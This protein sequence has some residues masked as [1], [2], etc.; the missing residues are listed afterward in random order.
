MLAYAELIL[1][2][3]LDPTG[4]LTLLGAMGFQNSA[5]LFLAKH[6]R[7]NEVEADATGLTIAALACYDVRRGTHFMR[8]LSEA[9]GSRPTS[10]W[11]T[12]PATEDRYADLRSSSLGVHE[13]VYGSHCTAVGKALQRLVTVP[14]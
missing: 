3:F 6:S 2:A 7:E 13:N 1:L 8:K 12:H 4:L 14:R 9:T 10:W 5:E 11:A